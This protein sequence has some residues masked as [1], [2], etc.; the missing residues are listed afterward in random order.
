M[1]ALLVLAAVPVSADEPDHAAAARYW[2]HWRGPLMTGA[3]PLAHPPL[4]W[5]ETENIRWKVDLPGSGHS[6]PVIWGDRVFVTAAVPVGPS[7]PPKYS[8]APGAH[9]NL[10]VTHRYEFVALALSRTDGRILWQQTLNEALPHEGGHYTGSMA[11]ASP[12]C[13]NAHVFAWFG[14]F[15]LFALDHDGNLQWHADLGRLHSK[16]GH[17]EGSSPVLWGD[18]LII[19]CDH[20][21]GS[22]LAAF[23][24]S[25]GEQKWKVP[26]DETT[27][28]SSPIV[29]EQD[30]TPQVV[31]AATNRIRGYD[32]ATGEELWAC[33]GLSSNVCAS[34]VAGGGL[35]FAGSN[36]DTRNLLAIRLAGAR[37]D[38]T[39]TDHVVWSRAEQTP[40]VPSLLL[41]DDSLYFLR[42]YQGILSRVSPGT[43][44][45]QVPTMR[46][47]GLRNIYSSPVAAAGRAYIT[48]RN[49][50]TMVLSHTNPPELLASNRL[51]DG[52][53]ASAALVEGEL[54]LRGEESLY[55]IVEE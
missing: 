3:A 39:G 19:N 54:Y 38:I 46:L 10:P 28:W 36:Y 7:L 25:T 45:D 20:E 22:F 52:F 23:N 47:G 32:L 11:S 21:E 14:S 26:R 43:G 29:V 42:I 8:D 41:Y 15:G 6:T 50:L 18:T 40:Y 2:P 44:E 31:V 17:G 16:H 49:G 1:L 55:C 33:G 4:T 53:S 37:G 51:E 13:D 48:D 35:V 34:P 27:S 5:S 12:V 30:G 24:K 9:D